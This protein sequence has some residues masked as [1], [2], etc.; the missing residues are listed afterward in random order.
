MRVERLRARPQRV[1]SRHMLRR[2]RSQL[3]PLGAGADERHGVLTASTYAKKEWPFKTAPEM[4]TAGIDKCVA[5]ILRAARTGAPAGADVH[6]SDPV[7]RAKA[8]V[9]TLV[10]SAPLETSRITTC[11]P[12]AQVYTRPVSGDGSV[13][14]YFHP[15]TAYG[16]VRYNVGIVY[17]V[18]AWVLA[19]IAIVH[20][21]R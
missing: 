3:P 15:R 1:T 13:D 6:V 11:L 8:F 10:S 17:V 4:T 12:G 14:V 7:A 16:G 21:E 2:R 5:S 18:L 19:A 9:V 20:R